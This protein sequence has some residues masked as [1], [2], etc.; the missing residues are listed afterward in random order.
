MT[1]V[2]EATVRVTAGAAAQPMPETPDSFGTEES[3]VNDP[4]LKHR[5]IKMFGADWCIDCR[6]AKD[7]FAEVGVPYRYINLE[8]DEAAAQVAEDIS[9]MKKIPVIVYSD[10][11]VQVEPS[12][13]Q[14]LQKLSEL[15]LV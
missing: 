15:G 2:P 13:A 9:G 10:N 5:E 12:R 4:G 7:T 1:H 3:E 11:S 14:I 6:R 8:E